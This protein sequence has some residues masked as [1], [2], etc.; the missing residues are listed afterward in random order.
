MTTPT[1]TTS[2]C[3]T[4]IELVD[5]WHANWP[6]VLESIDEH[7]HRPRL[8]IDA[9]GW[10]SARQVLLAA[11]CGERVAGHLCFDIEPV[12]AAQHPVPV[13]ARL[14]AFGIMP[15]FELVEVEPMLRSAAAKRA[16]ELRINQRIGF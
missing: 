2:T 12:A 4:R 15:G 5:N 3:A 14:N 1:T 13:R 11:F 7:G 10:L 6:A 16:D 9:D 8:R